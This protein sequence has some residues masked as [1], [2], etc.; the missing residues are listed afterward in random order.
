MVK[1]DKN[2]HE[3]GVRG[4]T[5]EQARES[6]ERWGSNEVIIKNHPLLRLLKGI[7]TDP[8]LLLLIA[9]SLIYFITGEVSHGIFMLF[10]IVLVYSISIYQEARNRKA[11]D[12]LTEITAP[13]AR[14]IRDGQLKSIHKKEIV[15]GDS[16]VVEEGNSIPADGTIVYSQDF[17]VNESV[18]TGESLPV[19]KNSSA[20][21]VFQGTS[22]VS[23][24]AI[25]EVTAIGERT[26][27]GKIGRS[28]IEIHEEK[29]PLQ[30]Q[31]D[32]FVKTVS[33]TGLLIFLTVWGWN[34]YLSGDVVNALLK[35]VALGMSII[36]EEIPIAFTTFMAI[37]A[38]KLI[39]YGIVVRKTSTVEALGSA[40]TICLDKT[41]TITENRMSLAAIFSLANNTVSNQPDASTIDVVT[42]AMWASEPVP[43]DPMEVA[44]HRAYE[45]SV[46]H[47]QRPGHKLI[48]EYALGG[49]PPMMTHVF[50][51]S[52]GKR[53]IAAK[54][55]VEAILKV[56]SLQPDERKRIEE[57][58]AGFSKEG[59]RVLAVA[60]S[61]FKGHEFPKDQH[62]LTFAFS[63][64][65]AFY[66]PP[67]KNI[68]EVFQAFY[69][70][71]VRVMIL[72]GDN[73]Q[74]T[75]TIARQVGFRYSERMLNG[76]QV[77]DM[78]EGELREAVKSVN[79]FTRMFPS[80][81]L[82]VLN[83]LKANGEVVAMTGDGVN[84]GPALK[85]AHV[86]IAMGKKG[87]TVAREVS[88]LVITDD[89]L[90][91]MID[92]IAAGRR[93]YSNLKKAIQYIVSIHIPIILTV[94]IP[95]ILGWAFPNIFTPVHIIFL[96]L[97]MGP[98]CSVVYENEPMEPGIMRSPP[99]PF[100]V[101]FFNRKELGTS[102][103][104]GLVITIASLLIY[105]FAVSE[106]FSEGQ[107]RSM[108]FVMLI[109]SNIFLTLVNRSFER[110]IFETL[111]YRNS[112][113]FGIISITI[114]LSILIFNIP[115]VSKFFGLD[116]TSPYHVSISILAGA[117][118]VLWL[119]G[120]KWFK[121]LSGPASRSRQ[122]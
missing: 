99:R 43:F 96:E 88:S 31:I 28:M 79:V 77:T 47:D 4:L 64:L 110:T 14:V 49:I 73:L 68:A 54:G 30:I 89:D 53:I 52:A 80:A 45:A 15:V 32:S 108:V 95:L 37:G 26:E 122:S 113:L 9:G 66:D 118:S 114:V 39:N 70:A 61:D 51:D 78:T 57:V 46:D 109:S 44:L 104:Q 58:A 17:S 3:S 24:L 23:G 112:L 81:K 117:V 93:I 13:E 115:Q 116:A 34:Y 75:M 20:S 59:F 38:W 82:K 90:G 10:A 25:F 76:Q 111:R 2:V 107:T 33:Y 98:T 69:D 63:G 7:V 97:I 100:T 101:T 5:S 91:H 12:A 22:A 67:R 120:F 74:T 83:A 119:E 85:A 40:T 62:A 1:P 11:L 41:G 8:M 84:D 35:A 27:L 42:T 60:Y 87:T 92:A 16:V 21:S 18:L 72:T 6:R 29:T 71:G 50:V 106:G 105:R 94:F 56:S 103:L 86:G 48:H 19:I 121:R 36:P 65:V 55:A 102:I